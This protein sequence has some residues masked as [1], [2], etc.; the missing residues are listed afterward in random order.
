MLPSLVVLLCLESEVIVLSL[1]LRWDLVGPTSMEVG[2]DAVELA[3]EVLPKSLWVDSWSW[4]S[5]SLHHGQI[6]LRASQPSSLSFSGQLAR[7][8]AG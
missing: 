7:L 4:T 1:P 3:E 5:S 8:L 6:S 2:E